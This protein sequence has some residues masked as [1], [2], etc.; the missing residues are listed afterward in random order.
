MVWSSGALRHLVSLISAFALVA[1]G[2]IAAEAAISRGLCTFSTQLA[3]PEMRAG[4]I[5]MVATAADASFSTR[6]AAVNAV[7][8]ESDG[9][10]IFGTLLDAGY[11]EPVASRTDTITT[12]CLGCHDGVSAPPVDAVQ[13]ISRVSSSGFTAQS[14]QT[15]SPMKT[16]PMGMSYAQ[17]AASGRGFRSPALVEQSLMLFDGTVSCLTCHNML[18]PRPMHLAVEDYRSAL[19]LTCH[20]K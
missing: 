5:G 6:T 19:C 14:V 20:I 15:A 17:V 1:A 16:H 11:H 3:D 2:S 12:A 10:A 9:F 4:Y 8:D 13:R 7:E 18:N